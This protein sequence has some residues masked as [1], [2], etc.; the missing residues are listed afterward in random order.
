MVGRR[1]RCCWLSAWMLLWTVLHS[2]QFLYKQHSYIISSGV[3]IVKF[4]KLVHH[5][6][7]SFKP[8]KNQRDR[9]L[10]LLLHV[11][12]HNAESCKVRLYGWNVFCHTFFSCIACWT[13]WSDYPI[14]SW[15]IFQHIR[16]LTSPKLLSRFRIAVLLMMVDTES[17][18]DNSQ[19]TFVEIVFNVIISQRLRQ[20][21]TL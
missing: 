19:R 8:D 4:M 2:L 20:L 7:Y 12:Y 5:W 13:V 11:I 17:W 9:H 15:S 3:P 10:Q 21:S 16:F 1:A 6:A 14:C 18:Y